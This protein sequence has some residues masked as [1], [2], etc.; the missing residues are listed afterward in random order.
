MSAL[1][2]NCPV[3]DA[4]VDLQADVSESEVVRCGDCGSDL[5]VQSLEPP[6][7]AEA[8]AEEEDWGE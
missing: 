2:A 7:L 6:R 1:S 5:E 4:T 3:C 8:P